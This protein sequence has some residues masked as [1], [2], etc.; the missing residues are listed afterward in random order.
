MAHST[1][2]LKVPKNLTI[3]LL[4]SRSPELNPVENIWQCLRQNWPFSSS[5]TASRKLEQ[6]DGVTGLSDV[7]RPGNRLEGLKGRRK[8]QRSIRI[9]EHWRI[10]FKWPEGSPGTTRVEIVDRDD[11]VHGA[12]SCVPS[13]GEQWGFPLAAYPQESGR[14]FCTHNRILNA[15]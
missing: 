12:V 4:P 14:R 3:I 1:D 13:A 2:K 5:R 8:G 7:S 10:C 9:H 15:H 6:I 11:C